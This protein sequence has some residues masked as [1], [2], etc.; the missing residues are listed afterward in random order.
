L[1]LHAGIRWGGLQAN[2]GDR[3]APSRGRR[4]DCVMKP[5]KD[6]FLTECRQER[7]AYAA[8]LQDCVEGNL[9]MRRGPDMVDVTSEHADHLRR[10]IED[11]DVLIADMEASGG[12]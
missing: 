1:G 10:I 9:T 5:A 11:L 7:G 4:Y 6:P 3:V 2:F 12:V 8:R